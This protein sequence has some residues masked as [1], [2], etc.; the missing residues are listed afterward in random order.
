MLSISNNQD[1]AEAK[2]AIERALLVG[3]PTNRPANMPECSEWQ[4]LAG[5]VLTATIT[6]DN[7]ELSVEWGKLIFAWWDDQRSQSWRVTA[8]E[9]DEAE[10]QLQVTRGLGNE[11]GNLTLRNQTRWR[12]KVEFENLELGQRRRL[13]A[14]TLAEMFSGGFFSAKVQRVTTGADRSHSVPGRYAR[15]AMK[16]RGETA[17]AIGATEAE[18]QTEIDGI[19]AAGLIWLAGFNQQRDQKQQTEKQAKR[20]LFCLPA[21]RSQTAIERMTL[22]DTTHLGARIECFEIDERRREISAMQ[23]ATQSELLNTHPRELDWPEASQT[24]NHWRERILRL[25]P[26]RIELRQIAGREIYSINGL[27]FARA[28]FG[29]KPRVVFGVAG[30]DESPA[31][32]LTEANFDRLAKLVGE[33]AEHRSAKSSARLSAKL[34]DRRNPFHRLREEA[35]LE[36]LLRQNISA[37]DTGFDDRFVYSQIPAWRGD[38]RSVIDLLTVNHEGRL[39]VIEVKASEDAQLPLQGLDYWLRVEQARLRGEF[40]RRGLFGGIE[41]ADKPPLLYLVAP[42]LRFHRTFAIVA[43]C[44]SPQIEAY[45]V[46]VNANWREGVRV[47]TCERIGSAQSATG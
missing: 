46:G 15:L 28:S 9:I 42:R 47:R 44:L 31:G 5:E 40:Q 45:Q 10:L 14:Q 12:E 39:V 30:L 17:L 3:M 16:L 35:W 6:A 41:L 25:A 34:G 8:Y 23:L 21:G 4:L 2:Y 27:E 32:T 20:L 22:L 18:S 37:L 24:E 29:E 19:I 38:E 7:C 33:I 11:I 13:Y 26:E 43:R 1:A 36:S